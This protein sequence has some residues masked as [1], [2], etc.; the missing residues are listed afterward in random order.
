MTQ[1]SSSSM[2]LLL[3]RSRPRNPWR[4][5]SAVLVVLAVLGLLAYVIVQVTSPSASSRWR[6][7]KVAVNDV[8]ATVTGVASIEPVSEA[9][10][11]FPVGGTVKTVD[12]AKGATVQPGQQLATIDDT[13]LQTTLHAKQA[14]LANAQLNLVKALDAQAA[15]DAASATTTTTTGGGGGGGGGGATPLQ[16]A[17]AR[18]VAAQRQVDTAIAQANTALSATTAP[19]AAP[20]TQPQIATCQSALQQAASAQTSVA[21]AQQNLATATSAL[22]ALLNQQAQSTSTTTPGGGGRPTGTTST[23][24]PSAATIASL[25]AQVDAAQAAVTVAEQNLLQASIVS[26]IAGTVVAINLAVGQSVSANSTTATVLVQGPGGFEA[27][28]AVSVDLIPDVRVTQ[29]ATVLPDGSETPITGRVSLIALAPATSTTGTTPTYRVTIALDGRP[30]ALQN[31]SIGTGAIITATAPGAVAIPTSAIRLS[32]TG[33]AVEVLDGSRLTLVPVEIGVA[34]ADRTQILSGL[35]VGQVVVLADLDEPLPGTATKA[36]TNSTSN[37]ANSSNRVTLPNGQTF[38]I[39]A[40]GFG[41]NSNGGNTPGGG[42]A[43]TRPGG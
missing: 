24:V 33:R 32:T 39:P 42:N 28:M 35:T 8:A 40:G 12:V 43:P 20:S 19:C 18:V 25:Q 22:D 34:G 29:R 11:A 9:T 10:V 13:A 16:Q 14:S 15:A 31:G 17:Q 36:R 21:S 4:P 37:N 6:T 7:A 23:T 5:A 26:P 2:E 30:S 3:E 38:Q 1:A 27:T 41:G